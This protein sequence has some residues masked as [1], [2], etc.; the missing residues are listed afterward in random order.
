MRN[1]L[2]TNNLH[3]RVFNHTLININEEYANDKHLIH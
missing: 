2:T 3:N 1:G